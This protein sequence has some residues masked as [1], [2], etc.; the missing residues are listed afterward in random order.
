MTPTRIQ[1]IRKKGYRHPPN[2]LYATRP[3]PHGNPYSITETK[4]ANGITYYVKR[5][6]GKIIGDFASQSNAARFACEMFREYLD[7]MA[8][9][10]R[11][12][13]IAQ[14]RAADYIACSC[15]LIDICHA[16]IWIELSQEGAA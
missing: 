10:K 15:K 1:R 7:D 6:D 16:D 14:V 12:T 3:L 5:P 9:T 13:L 4:H 8:H 11:K 2:T